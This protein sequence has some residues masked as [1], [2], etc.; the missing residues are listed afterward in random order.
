MIFK[1]LS[2][3]KNC[4]GPAIAPLTLS[5]QWKSNLTVYIRLD[6]TRNQI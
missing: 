6:V 2:V 1:E 4:L 5:T 3:A